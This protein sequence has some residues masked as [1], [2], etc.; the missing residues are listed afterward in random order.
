[1][2]KREAATFLLRRRAISIIAVQRKP[3]MNGVSSFDLR[4]SGFGLLSAF[5]LRASDFE[6]APPLF[7][8]H[9]RNAL[10]PGS[11]QAWKRAVSSGV[12]RARSLPINRVL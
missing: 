8:F 7:L 4:P 9:G 3:V 2:G 10:R 1:M 5:G 6:F 12:V 11:C